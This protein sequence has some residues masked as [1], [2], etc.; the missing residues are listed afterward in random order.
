MKLSALCQASRLADL[1]ASGAD[2]EITS[3]TANSRQVVPGALFAALPGSHTHGSRFIPSAL[4]AGANAILHDGSHPVPVPALVHPNPRRALAAVAA[5]FY[6]H[7]ADALTMIGI[8]GSNGKTT[9]A[10]MVESI[11]HA[12]QRICGVI[13]TTG[14][15]FPGCLRP[16]SLTTPDPITFQSTLAD[17]RAAGCHAVISEVS[18]HALI[19]SRTA[20]ILW[21]AAAFTNLSRDHLDFHGTMDA[22]WQAKRS[23]FFDPPEP[24]TAILN[25]DDPRGQELKSACQARNIPVLGFAL[26][27]TTGAEVNASAIQFGWPHSRFLLHTPHGSHPIRLPAAGRFNVAN[28]LAATAIGI[29]IGIP[30]EQI[31]SG[32]ESF[33]PVHG[34]MEP[35]HAGQPFTV[36]VDFAHTPDALERLLT[37]VRE[38][39]PTGQ[40]LLL[41]GCGGD[42]DPGKRPIMGEIAGRLADF[43]VITDDNPR[44]EDPA[45]IRA[46]ICSGL[47]EHTSAYREIGDRDHAIGVVLAMAQPN[48]VVLIVGKGHETGQILAT[49]TLPFDDAEVTRTHLRR[50]HAGQIRPTAWNDQINEIIFPK[51]A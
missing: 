6:G 29:C 32:L 41:F 19:L 45:T 14:I 4:A 36:L 23:L 38:M 39:T 13:G 26:N 43:T 25:L 33:C 51:P 49:H 50:L 47:Q 37:T 34:R 7:P 5:A 1:S 48:D 2:V 20:G 17:M 21:H 9:V 3:L 8:T 44:S 27:D 40:V 42:R 35:I 11:L 12:A 18:S 46:A 28:A 15:R 31:I 10:A 30:S 24:R 16:P 22:Y